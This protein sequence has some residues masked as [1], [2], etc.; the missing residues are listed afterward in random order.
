MHGHLLGAAGAVEGIACVLALRDGIIPP[1]IN[2]E[3][4]DPECRLDYVPNVARKA[5][6]EIALSSGFGFG[7]HNAVIAFAKHV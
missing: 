3:F 1:T 7:G 4:P 5:D 6:I 2:Y